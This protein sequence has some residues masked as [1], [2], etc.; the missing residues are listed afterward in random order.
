MRADHAASTIYRVFLLVAA[1]ACLEAAFVSEAS[2]ESSPAVPDTTAQK[3][4]I[5]PATGRVVP[6]EQSPGCREALRPSQERSQG[7]TDQSAE[8][9]KEEPLPQGGSK[10]DLQGRFQQQGGTVPIPLAPP[11]GG[12]IAIIDPTTG[13]LMTGEAA[14]LMRRQ[15][16]A[17]APDDEFE[18]Q[19]R[20]MM[21]A[22][23]DVSGLQE[24]QLEGGT[25]LLDLGG[26]FQ[27]PLV[28]RVVPGGALIVEH[29]KP[30]GK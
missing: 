14:T 21:A 26:R 2:A 1:L 9:L 6:P 29:A 3:A 5:D 24:R 18:R 23:E 20:A 28:A 15:G 10:M 30:L 13:N 16:A 11:A 25:V 22:A 27:N 19:L 8:G 12:Q 7:T 17:R 4:C